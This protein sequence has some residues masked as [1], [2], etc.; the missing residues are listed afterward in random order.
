[1]KRIPNT[2][3]HSPVL[4]SPSNVDVSKRIKIEFEKLVKAGHD[5]NSAAAT[6]LTIIAN[7]T[8]ERNTATIIPGQLDGKVTYFGKLRVAESKDSIDHVLSDVLALNSAS[9]VQDVLTTALK[10]LR[11]SKNE[12]CEPKYR[13]FKLSNKIADAVTRVVGGLDLLQALGFEVVGT[14]QDFKASIPVA[15]NMIAMEKKIS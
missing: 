2:S 5:P 8:N 1:L 6:A 9:A 13:S 12:P 14:Y 3:K 11:N 15:A 10:Y 7:S 4:V